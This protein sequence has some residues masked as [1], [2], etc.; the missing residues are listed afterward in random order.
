[1][2]V[3]AAI[4]ARVS[5]AEQ[6]E[7]HTIEGQLLVLRPY[8]SGQGWTLV[9]IYVDDGRS[10]RT[11]KLE[12]RDGFA[13]LVRDAEAR[14]F[15]VLVVVHIDRL[16]R[17]EDMA[18]R[19]AI[20]GPFQRAGIRIA[21]PG[22]G[23][24]DL[25]TMYG[26]MWTVMQA[27]V[28]AE[29]NRH[30]ADRIRA[31]KL[32]AIAEGRKPAGPT[33][34]GLAYARVSGSWSVDPDRAA[35]VREIYARVIAGESCMVIADDLHAR[36]APPPRGPWSRNKVWALVRSRHPAGEWAA[37]KRRRLTVP[38]PAIVDE[39]TWAAA[40]DSLI[41]HGKR[42]LRRSR[43]VYLLEGLG[44]CGLCG[45][46]MAIRSTAPSRG[47]KASPAAYVCRARKLARRGAPRCRA[48][49]IRVADAD[50]RLWAV[51][52][53]AL[54]DPGLPARVQ[55][56]CESQRSDRDGWAADAAGYERRLAQLARAEAGVLRRLRDELVSDR[57]ADAELAELAR[58]R[59]AVSTQLATARRAASGRGGDGADLTAWIAAIR[60][61]AAT[62]TPA[63]QQVLVRR[64]VEPG[65]VFDGDRIRITMR[66]S[67]Q[68]SS[69]LPAVGSSTRTDR[70][71]D[72]I[73]RLVA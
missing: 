42:G 2:T 12:A 39:A 71:G 49:I 47:A 38:V 43:H 24:L 28:A 8:V 25:R 34:Y 57:A 63:E 3:R 41:A 65:A 62:A 64:L 26:E 15:D 44:V 61:L 27:L 69:D 30:R 13:R 17:T 19:A 60:D 53:A 18:E 55:R 20:L 70:Q 51:V 73:L 16:T 54:S 50:R 72:V 36:G 37:D 4:Y 5:S 10:A 58:A 32:R 35:I 45:A 56:I 46:P 21:T 22:G 7:R 59:A 11:G 1:M 40:Q 23:E 68:N 48:P 66:V 29:E 14:R 9:D 6:R 31:G 67:A 52:G 33:P